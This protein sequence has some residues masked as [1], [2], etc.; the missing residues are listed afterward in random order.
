LWKSGQFGWLLAALLAASLW[1]YVQRVLVPFQQAEA[2]THGRPRGMLSDLYPRWLGTREL[3]L[4]HRDPYADDVTREIQAGYYGRPLDAARA[5]DPRDEERFAYPVYV[6]FLLAPTVSLPF[7]A[8]RD[9]FRWLLGMVTVASIVLWLRV[10]RWRPSPNGFA[11]LLLLTLGSYCT[12]QG[13]KLEQLSLLVCG[14]IAAS[15]VFLVSGQLFLAGVLLAV[16]TIK[17]QL[18][19]LLTAWLMLWTLSRWRERQGFFW[20]FTLSC[21][22]LA[23]GGE[24]VLPGWIER[25]AHAVT[26]YLDYTDA[27]SP[28]E[29]LTTHPIGKLLGVVLVVGVAGIGWRLR[30][31]PADSRD[32]HLVLALVLTTTLAVVP[33]LAPY[34]QLLLLPAVF[35][36]AQSWKQLWQKSGGSQAACSAAAVFVLWPWMVSLGL[37]LASLFLAPA[38]IERA[39]ALPLWSSPA[40]PIAILGPLAFL[41]S[42]SRAFRARPS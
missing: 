28:L 16:A 3:L 6:A 7:P 22:L 18:V 4:H 34:N 5:G 25:F 38:T 20:G 29:A 30:Q 35:L 14:V 19:V 10:L 39:W 8:V 13:I 36:I 2:A 24:Y 15:A 37:M 33:M 9:A 21:A 1:F 32:F 40:I 41:F 26:A 42:D 11:V 23:G 27:G 31:S 17:P 12:V